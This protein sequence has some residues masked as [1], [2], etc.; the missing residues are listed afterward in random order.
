MFK[1]SDGK[2]EYL[3]PT[4]L[5]K[6]QCQIKPEY[7]KNIRQHIENNFMLPLTYYTT[8]VIR[9]HNKDI[10]IHYG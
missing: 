1:L 8:C 6:Y 10:I 7:L 9:A 5:Y 3:V 4:I 2:M